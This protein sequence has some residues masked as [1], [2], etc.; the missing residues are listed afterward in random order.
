MNICKSAANCSLAGA[1]LLLS[2]HTAGAGQADQTN[3]LP[4][5]IYPL[6]SAQPA[7]SDAA[8]SPGIFAPVAAPQTVQVIYGYSYPPGAYY[9]AGGVLA[10]RPYGENP[11]RMTVAPAV[12][13]SN[14]RQAGIVLPAMVR[15]GGAHFR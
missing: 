8:R 7:A 4:T 1:F 15:S 2:L 12:S 14:R 10:R 6:S 9:S 11:P 3:P 13:L 5:V